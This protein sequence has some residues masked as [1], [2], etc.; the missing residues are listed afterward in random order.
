MIKEDFVPGDVITS[1]WLNAV[2]KRTNE[3]VSVK[4]APYNAKGD[5]V[6]DDTA[7]IQAALDSAKS[8]HFPA[9]T[10]RITSPITL[11]QNIFRI[12]GVKGKSILMG[13]GGA[14]IIGYF[15]VMQQFF[16][17]FGSIED[18]TFDSDD[19][20]KTRWAIYSPN[21][22]YLAHWRIAECNF[23]ARL[24]GGIV[25]NLIACHIYKC[26]FGVYYAGDGNNLT[27]IQSTGT[28]N[29]Y[30][31]TTNINVIEQC[32]FSNCGSPNAV[33]AFSTGYKLVFR[34]CVFEQLTPTSA[35]VLLSGISYPEFYNCWFENAQGTTGPGKSVIWTRKDSNDIFCEVLT[36]Q[37]CLFHTYSS[38]PDGLVNFSDSQRKVANF[39]NNL[40]ISL[41]SPVIV[42][43]N[44]GA[45]FIGS[46]G[47][48]ATVGAGGDA[49]GLQ[50]DSPAKFDLGVSSPAIKFPT[51]Q[52]PSS[53]P[54][55]LDDY[56]EGTW[57][58]SGNGVALVLN[59]EQRYVKIGR[60]VTLNVDVSWP[61]TSDT[62]QAKILGLPFASSVKGPVAIGYT[63]YT[64]NLY[65]TAI[66][67]AIEL[68]IPGSNLNNNNMSGHQFVG[69]I[70]YTV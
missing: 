43:G 15:R 25:A 9:G 23:N 51:T 57:T 26:Y 4:E 32:E 49:S 37:G 11:S 55:T 64:G 34:E 60:V 7:A 27:A 14:N 52:V 50:Y 63:T 56:E 16:A 54:N 22:V 45:S 48:S 39:T 42:G 20:T 66:S 62:A 41:Q 65:S 53:D 8:V 13:S 18:L 70:T 24:T 58:P 3:F 21:D 2:G 29:P 17:D 46:F 35:V 61:T 19:S 36:V 47:N 69:Q 40:M 68:K 30:V 67:S 59:G 33:V 28:V 44:S 38:V 5:G 10:Y 31:A 12:T 1:G 6:A